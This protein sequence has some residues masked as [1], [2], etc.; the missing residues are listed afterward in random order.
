[1]I[2]GNIEKLNERILIACSRGKRDPAGIKTVAVSKG[3]NV[4]DIKS[5]LSLGM[6]DFGESRIQEALPKFYEIRNTKYGQRIKWH[7]VGHLQ[8]NKVRDA[9]MIFDLI[10]SVDSVRLAREINKEAGKLNKAQNILLEV[11]TSAEAT[12]YGFQPE[13]TVEAVGQITELKSIRVSGLMT[14]SPFTDDLESVRGSF[15]RLKKIRDGI[16]SGL[17]LSMGMSDDFQ[18]AIEE[19]ADILR[20][21]RAI[22]AKENE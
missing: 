3:R 7:M 21:G 10:H 17:L 18:I 8:T 20:I 22:F 12:K 11:K 13:E 4:E 1:M 19:G 14:I 16:D 2:D 5:V 9:V 15:R 6:A